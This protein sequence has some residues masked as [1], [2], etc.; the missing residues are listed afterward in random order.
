[1]GQR[2]P[3]ARGQ[4]IPEL[5]AVVTICQGNGQVPLAALGIDDEFLQGMGMAGAPRKTGHICHPQAELSSTSGRGTLAISAADFPEDIGPLRIT[6]QKHHLGARFSSQSRSHGFRLGC[7]LGNSTNQ[8]V[9]IQC[10]ITLDAKPLSQLA[11]LLNGLACQLLAP[12]RSAHDSK[13]FLRLAI[14]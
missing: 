8:T 14:V 3:A 2:Q 13:T 4:P 10:R 6:R 5:D 1:M 11:Q 9:L 7:A 12:G